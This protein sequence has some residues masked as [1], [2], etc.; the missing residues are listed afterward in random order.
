MTDVDGQHSDIEN[1]D[2]LSK[3]DDKITIYTPEQEIQ[4][5]TRLIENHGYCKALSD[6]IKQLA[7]ARK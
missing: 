3:V 6:R 2:P 1:L 4:I 7:R 5:L